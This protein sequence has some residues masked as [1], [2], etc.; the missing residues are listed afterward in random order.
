MAPL[1]PLRGLLL[2]FQDAVSPMDSAK[3]PVTLQLWKRSD[4]I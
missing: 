1:Q 2:L 4:Q 3:P